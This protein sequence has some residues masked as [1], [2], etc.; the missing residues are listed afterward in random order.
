MIRCGFVALCAIVAGWAHSVAAQG[1]TVDSL[2]RWLEKYATAWESRSADRAAEIF[3]ADALYQDTPFGEPHRGRAGIREYWSRVTADQRDV[4]FHS[5]VIAV[6]GATGIA[7]W[8]AAFRLEN[9][10]RV[11]LDG[12]FV[13]AFDDAGLCTSLR[14]WWHVREP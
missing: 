4:S 14:E 12:V 11:E 8:S 7:H 13:L 5:E 10:E 9:G 6:N 3:A 1:L 2:E